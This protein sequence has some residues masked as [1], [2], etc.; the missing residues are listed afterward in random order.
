M[1]RHSAIR[2]WL[3]LLIVALLLPVQ[4]A[5]AVVGVV[6]PFRDYY[7]QHDGVRVLGYPLTGLT[8]AGG[9]QAQ[10]FEKGRIEDHR[11]EVVDSVWGFMYGRLTA[12]LMALNPSGAVNATS[13]TYAQLAELHDPSYRHAPPIGFTSGVMQLPTGA[14]FIPDD[15]L[16]RRA[17][18]YHVPAR[19][20]RYMNRSDLFPA[21]WLHDIGLPLTDAVQVTTI[22]NGTMRT[23][24]LQ[25]FERT[26]LTDD[27][28]NPSAWQ[29]ERGNLGLDSINI[30]P[31]VSPI[32]LPAV[33]SHATLPLHIMARV[34]V[35][36]QLLAVALR[37]QDGTTLRSALTALRGEDGRGLLIGSINWMQ[38][39]QPPQPPSQWAMLE[40]SDAR[41]AILARQGVFMLSAADPDTRVVQLYWVLGDQVTPF[42]RH[43]VSTPRIG[44][45]ALEELLWGPPP[46][47]LAGFETALPLPSEVLSYAGRESDWGPRV[48]LLSLNIV[49][50]VATANFSQELRAY[51]GGSLRVHFITEQIRQT[52]LQFPSVHTV[53]IAI[54]GRTDG[55]LEP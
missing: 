49:D 7:N 36:G 12:E 3:M 18:G 55:V 30:L 46:P 54:E 23:I 43:I 1:F 26:V 32:E 52:L 42:E 14:V 22:K 25:A 28:L 34:G 20:W 33:G 15:P 19:F 5:Q 40:I 50:G 10:Y 8:E 41:G 53:R 27:P 51:G 35:P 39:S 13:L 2:I 44:A 4:R 31:A 11:S 37:W 17:P 9:Y 45:A 38:E 16:L 48:R 21:G 24:L 47:N 29:I 6:E